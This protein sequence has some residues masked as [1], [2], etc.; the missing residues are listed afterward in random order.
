MLGLT[1]THF[2]H[3]VIEARNGKEGLELFPDACAD[4]V[5]TDIVMPEKEGLEVL[6]ELRKQ[7]PPVKIIVISGGTRNRSGGYLRTATALGAPKVLEKPFSN[8]EL[9]NAV[10]ELLSIDT[11]K[12]PVT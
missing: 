5:I 2:G 12:P 1:L 6:M 7:K 11:T 10:N 4:L 8:G 3:L 9:M